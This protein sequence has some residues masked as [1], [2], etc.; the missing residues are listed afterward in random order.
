MAEIAAN[1]AA[2]SFAGGR[3]VVAVVAV[4]APAGQLLQG[5]P[6]DL[7]VAPTT[8]VVAAGLAVQQPVRVDLVPLVGRHRRRPAEAAS[9]MS[10]LATAAALPPLAGP[11]GPL[12][13]GG[14]SR[15]NW[16][17]RTRSTRFCSEREMPKQF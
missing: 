16:S 2:G 17:W 11:T 3:L 7:P 1:G 13:G 4:A 14:R 6:G 8:G 9:A 5:G 10:V 15:A 12:G